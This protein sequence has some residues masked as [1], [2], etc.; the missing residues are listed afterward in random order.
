MKKHFFTGLV[1]I[2]PFFLT[3]Y[4]IWIVFKIVGKFFTPVFTKIFEA[5]VPIHIP[6][7]AIIFISAAVTL[8]LIWVIGIL[9]SNFIGKKFFHIA[10]KLLLKIPM[11]SGIYDAIKKLM[12]GFFMDKSSFK[13]V[14][15][16]E[17]PRKGIYSIAFITADTMSEIPTREEVINVFMPSTPNLTTGFF[18]LVPKDDMIPLKMSVDDAI[19]LIISGGIVVPPPVPIP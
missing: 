2:I 10:E 16:I 18:M 9:A 13:R 8:F 17:W 4:I 3:A 15:L 5:F 7:F 6:N 1:I 11:A 19:K 14:V 12:K